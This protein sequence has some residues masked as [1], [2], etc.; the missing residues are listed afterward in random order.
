VQ[1]LYRWLG[2]DKLI[3]T[4]LLLQLQLLA[5]GPWGQLR[6][7]SREETTIC[8]EFGPPLAFLFLR[9]MWSLYSLNQRSKKWHSS[10]QQRLIIDWHSARSQQHSINLTLRPL[11]I[12]V[13]RALV[14]SLHALPRPAQQKRMYLC[15]LR[16]SW[17]RL[18][19]K[20]RLAG[21]PP[22]RHQPTNYR[23]N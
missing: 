21:S 3:Y 8:T 5:F 17:I 15:V 19:A 14:S 10:F 22:S 12:Q 9:F 20:M 2:S 7:R 18:S 23:N 1:F 16:R 4:L 6:M 11:F 13:P